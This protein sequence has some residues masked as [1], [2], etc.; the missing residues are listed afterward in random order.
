[1]PSSQLEYVVLCRIAGSVYTQQ[2]FSQSVLMAPTKQTTHT[3]Y[4]CNPSLA[5][6]EKGQPS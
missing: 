5:K 6:I 2:N 3:H 4:S 1:M